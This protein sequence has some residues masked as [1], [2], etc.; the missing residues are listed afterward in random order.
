LDGLRLYMF[1]CIAAIGF[2]L[3]V[4]G[5]GN[6]SKAADTGRVY[7]LAECLSKTLEYSRDALIAGEGIKLS[8]GRYIEERA[9]ALPQ[10]RAEAHFLRASDETNRL[11]GLGTDGNEYFG[12]INLSQA[13]FTWGQIGA[14][15]KAAKYDKAASEQQYQAARQ[16]AMR[17]AATAFYDL[18]LTI[19]LEKV[20]RDNVAQK[21]RHLDEAERR[22]QLEA[23]TDYDILSARV[24]LANA[25]PSQIQAENNIRVATDRLRYYMGVQGDF[26]VKGVLTVEP[27]EQEPLDIVLA[28]AREKRPDVASQNNRIDTYRELL[29]VAKAGNKPRLDFKS[30]VGWLGMSQ[31]ERESPFQ[32]W[33]AG[34]YLS[35]PIFDGQQT[36]GKVIQAESRV[37]TSR[38][39]LDKLFDNIA[40][41]ARVARNNAEEA[42]HIAEGLKAT[43]SQA[44]KLL[45][46]A[47]IGYRHGVKTKL[48]VDDAESNVLSSRINLLRARRDYINARVR[49]L[50]IMGE[51]LQSAL[52]DPGVS[53]LKVE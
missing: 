43:T 48:E 44:E 20:A 46:M 45:E 9:A 17:E 14:A 12:N 15:I 53:K 35:M 24:A 42:A 41:D 29:T 2:V 6:A 19:E 5:I 40:L 32:A 8:Q 13:L 23:A 11:Q 52:F 28:T 21:Q 51:D 7:T 3:C 16:L 10:V 18:L 1:T 26:S 38:Y 33:D 31:L 27:R 50:W 25:V 34:V 49:L 4:A 47:E 36:K 39:E 37:S 22:R 30:N